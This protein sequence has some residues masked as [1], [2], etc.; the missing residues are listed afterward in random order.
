[1][2]IFGKLSQHLCRF[3]QIHVFYRIRAP[4]ALI[5]FLQFSLS[6]TPIRKS[7]KKKKRKKRIKVKIPNFAKY[8]CQQSV[9]KDTLTLWTNVSRQVLGRSLS[10]VLIK[11]EP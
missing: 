7:R 5:A 2:N 3:L 9:A 11:H 1:M 4:K 10:L 6:F 8:V